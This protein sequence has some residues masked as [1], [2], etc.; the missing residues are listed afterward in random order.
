M[1]ISA[2]E[3]IYPVEIENALHEHPAVAEAAVIGVPDPRWGEAVKAVVVLRPAAA[4]TATDIIEFLRGRIAELKL[5]RSVEFAA[6]LPRTPSGK[7]KK[8]ELR[9]PYWRGRERLVN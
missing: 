5:P 9:A 7:V 6:A 3:N 2:G 1:I 4:A 8:T